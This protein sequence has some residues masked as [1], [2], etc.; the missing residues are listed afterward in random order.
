[1]ARSKSA[2]VSDQMYTNYSFAAHQPVFGWHNNLIL[3][4]GHATQ[5]P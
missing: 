3:S 5:I 1:M 2:I 4:V